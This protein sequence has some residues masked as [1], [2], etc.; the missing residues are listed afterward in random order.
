MAEVFVGRQP[1]FT[2]DLDVYGYELLFRSHDGGPI[3]DFEHATAQVLVNTFMEFGLASLVGRAIPFVNVTRPFLSGE[4]PLPFAPGTAV[5]EILETVEV[6]DATVADVERLVQ[7]GHRFALD[8]Y[9]D[10]PQVRR[11]FELVEIMKIDI[12]ATS[13]DKIVELVAM[14]REAGLRILAEKVETEEQ[15]AACREL[16]FDYYQGFLLSRPTVLQQES[17]RSGQLGLLR[18]VT[19][20]GDPRAT[21]EEVESLIRLDPGLSHRLLKL[22]NSAGMNRRPQL[23]SIHDAVI[24]LGRKSLRRWLL[25]MLMAEGTPTSN[26]L[27]VQALVRA[28]MCELLASDN[29]CSPDT[30]FTTGLLSKVDSLVGGP[31]E[32]VLASLE[33][34]DA[35]TAALL[36][37]DDEPLGR[38]LRTVTAYERGAP[39]WD[40]PLG[41][42]FETLR[43]AWADATAW[44]VEATEMV[45]TD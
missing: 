21:S 34:D 20:I 2:A 14:A 32:S 3:E 36:D 26:E 22:V 12:L 39:A 10:S 23:P 11:L 5:L 29:G 4:I 43:R 9:V 1:I 16:D 31:V 25:V 38:L 35:V 40:R 33:V 27:I 18:L 37:T 6:D 8:D 19:M 41:I 15:L 7:A 24:V 42:S 45:S 30:A 44:A 17:V 28:R 13:W